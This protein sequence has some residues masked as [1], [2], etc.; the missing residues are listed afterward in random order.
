V[1]LESKLFLIYEIK[2]IC[3]A[4]MDERQKRPFVFEDQTGA[5]V[6]FGSF[7]LRQRK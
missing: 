1:K 4:L 5:A 3:P 2:D 7:S 6:S